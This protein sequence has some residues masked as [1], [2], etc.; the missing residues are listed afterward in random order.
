LRVAIHET[1]HALAVL[2]WGKELEVISCEGGTTA[3][4]TVKYSSLTPRDD[5][6]GP[7]GTMNICIA[8]LVAEKLCGYP[9]QYGLESDLNSLG[10]AAQHIVLYYQT[11][12]RSGLN[13]VSRVADTLRA[14]QRK[15]DLADDKRDLC[16]SAESQVE[17]AFTVLG[18][19]R[20]R[21]VAEAVAERGT[22]SGKEFEQL[23]LDRLG[24]PVDE[25]VEVSDPWHYLQNNRSED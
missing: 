8:G 23:V 5:I 14:E 7:L 24:S 13:N 20:L 15:Q 3:L 19:E 17:E 4:G 21:R 12:H 1:G 22:M 18:E 9:P 10:Q 25:L 6:S 2:L 11:D 16:E